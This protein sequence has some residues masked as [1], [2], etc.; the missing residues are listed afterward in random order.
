VV[1]TGTGG[2]GTAIARRL[3]PGRQIVLADHDADALARAAGALRGDGFVV[4][5]VLTDVSDRDAVAGLAKAAAALGPIVG[6]AHTAGVSPAQAT[7]ERIMQVD[8]L[9]TAYVLD[10]FEPHAGPGTVIV[11]IASMAGAMVPVAAD[12]EHALATTPTDGLTA[13]PA[14]DPSDLDPGMAYVM[15]KRANQ[16]RVQAASVV[17][18]QRGAR[19]VSVSPGI[20]AT[21]MGRQ[22]LSSPAGEIMQDMVDRSGTGRLGVPDDIASVVEFLMSPAASFITGTDILV[23]GGAVA[24]FRYPL[25]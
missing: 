2:M 24:A 25:D 18:G 7:P 20:I 17:W 14:L 3:G 1:V 19:V 13:I 6:I 9:G 15:A 5:E 22:E 4:H 23:D 10:E 11:C 16:L 21:P 8:V 12:V